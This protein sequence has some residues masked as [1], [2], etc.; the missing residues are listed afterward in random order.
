MVSEGSLQFNPVLLRKEEFLKKPGTFEYRDIKGQVKQIEL[1]AGSV[2]FTYCQIPIV[3]KSSSKKGLRIV[4]G[5]EETLKMDTLDLGSDL[6]RKVF[7]R[8][9]QIDQIT[10]SF[11][12]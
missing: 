12:K 5:N 2:A 10:V 3:Y 8:T 11:D 6:S 9:G 4:M 1:E 7:R